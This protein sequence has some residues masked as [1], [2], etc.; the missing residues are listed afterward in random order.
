M[1][2]ECPPCQ[3]QKINF[4]KDDQEIY[5]FWAY[6]MSQLNNRPG[7]L[8]MRLKELP[9]KH[10]GSL[11]NLVNQ[12]EAEL[13][14]PLAIPVRIPIKKSFFTRKPKELS[15]E[16]TQ[17]NQKAEAF[18]DFNACR[19]YVL[20]ETASNKSQHSDIA[21]FVSKI[22]HYIES[23]RYDEAVHALQKYKNIIS[24]QA[25]EEKAVSL[26]KIGSKARKYRGIFGRI[27]RF[28]FEIP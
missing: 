22:R 5:K 4:F 27:F 18:E 11:L 20:G 28:L 24:R 1:Q 7:G 21:P 13:K 16:E 3:C 6:I 25:A 12:L 26:K 23:D 14:D 10:K 9:K 17:Q 2:Q 15:E 8:S 19:A